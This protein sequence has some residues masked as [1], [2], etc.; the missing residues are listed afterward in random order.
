[1]IAAEEPTQIVINGTPGAKCG[2]TIEFGDGTR[3]SHVVSDAAPFP[4]RIPHTYPKM[5]DHTIRVSGLASAGAP[6][7]EGALDVAIHISP[8]G[9]KV[10]FIT[11]AINACPEGWLLVGEVNPDKSFKCTPIPDKSAPTNLIHCTDGMKYFARGGN[12]GCAHPVAAAQPA[13]AESPPAI[14]KRGSK[15]PMPV[16][17][18][19]A[20]AAK[21]KPSPPSTSKP[22]RT[23][24][25]PS[26]AVPAAQTSAG[27]APTESKK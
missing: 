27:S 6:P 25:S 2:L 11:L 26:K 19:S 14:P 15:G 13:L 1:M 5:A 7:C 21:P 12:V 18:A 17:A 10:E 4:L 20:T 23:K 16:K 22:S 8:A 3:S 24:A 9:S